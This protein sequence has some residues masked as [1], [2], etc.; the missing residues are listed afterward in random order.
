M[1]YLASLASLLLIAGSLTPVAAQQPDHA[2]GV[3]LPD[4]AVAVC[5]PTQGNS[6]RGVVMFQASGDVVQIT[7][8][9]IGLTPGKHGFHIHEFGDLRSADGTSAG[10]HYSPE[11]HP[12]GGPDD[13]EHHAGDL[14]N[15]TANEDG[16]AEIKMESK[17]LKVHFIL[18]RTVVIHG[19]EDDLTSQPS[20]D[21]GPRVAVGVIGVANP[22]E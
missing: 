3:A 19:G 7:G 14:G 9:V 11:G 12:H 16:V 10:G 13:E 2:H 5:F 15:I 22:E 21:A 18:G 6:V 1:K 4:K 8:K 20:G 17:D